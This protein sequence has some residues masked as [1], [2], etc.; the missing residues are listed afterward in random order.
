MVRLCHRLYAQ[1]V[2]FLVNNKCRNILSKM[3]D[4]NNLGVVV[5]SHH[6]DRRTETSVGFDRRLA[7]FM[8]TRSAGLGY[9]YSHQTLFSCLILIIHL[10]EV[11]TPSFMKWIKSERRCIKI[12]THKKK[13]LF[14]IW[15]L[16]NFLFDLRRQADR[17]CVCSP[18]SVY[19]FLIISA[20]LKTG[21]F[22]R[23]SFFWW[24]LPNGSDA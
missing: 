6:D 16:V 8:S 12:S 20:R 13:C 11:I 17:N 14:C 7:P 18:P 24:K 10:V 21:V 22:Y 9:H 1:E 5:L 23:L 15:S 3:K 2:T 19:A 4:Y